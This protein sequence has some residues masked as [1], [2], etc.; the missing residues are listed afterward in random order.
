MKENLIFGT[1]II[2][3]IAMLVGFLN[4]I[5]IITTQWNWTSFS[6]V[7]LMIIASN[8]QFL[9]KGKPNKIKNARILGSVMLLGGAFHFFMFIK[10]VWG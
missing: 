4:S 2:A 1:V 5:G 7:F 3:L 9:K 6:L 8:E 10:S